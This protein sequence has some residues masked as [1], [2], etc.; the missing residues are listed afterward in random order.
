MEER[1]QEIKHAVQEQLCLKEDASDEEVIAIIDI[2]IQT[3]SRSH[4]LSLEHK[5][6]I[7]REL[8]NTIK[9]L[10][11]IQTFR[12]KNRKCFKLRIGIHNLWRTK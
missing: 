9:R 11:V 5:K 6:E 8:F 3:D 7:R 2:C 4:F 1:K 10:D 12:Q